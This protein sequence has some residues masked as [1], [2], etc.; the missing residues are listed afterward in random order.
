[1]D[2]PNAMQNFYTLRKHAYAIYC[3]VKGPENDSD[4]KKEIFFLFS[5]QN[6]DCGY[7]LES[8]HL[9]PTIYFLEQK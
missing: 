3:D 5:A 7:T 4:E 9:V 2:Y 6:I 1:M 8:P